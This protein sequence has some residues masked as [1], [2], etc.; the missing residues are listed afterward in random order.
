M[1]ESMDYSTWCHEG[2]RSG[3][4]E[5]TEIHMGSDMVPGG[6]R[7]DGLKGLGA[8]HVLGDAAVLYGPLVALTG[9]RHVD[10][11][12][13]ERARACGVAA[14]RAGVTLVTGGA[15]G[16]ELEAAEACLEEGGSVVVIPGCGPDA[17]YQRP[18]E[19]VL[20]AAASGQGCVC[21]PFPLGTAPRRPQ[22]HQRSALIAS[23]A[24]LIVCP[25]ARPRS[26]TLGTLS[27]AAEL[28]TRIAL[29]E[30]CGVTPR[31]LFPT[32]CDVL[33]IPGTGDALEE[34]L[35]SHM[36]EARA[37]RFC[38]E[39]AQGIELANEAWRVSVIDEGD[40]FA[41]ECETIGDVSGYDY[42]GTLDMRSRDPLDPAAWALE[43]YDLAESF[44]VDHEVE[45]NLGGRGAPG[46]ETMVM[47]FQDIRDRLLPELR[48]IVRSVS[49]E[50]AERLCPTSGNEPLAVQATPAH[51]RALGDDEA[52]ANAQPER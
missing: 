49:S 31:D 27:K 18:T 7:G 12:E 24:D 28:G 13:A 10:G 43:A 30:G 3:S 50:V 48:D 20:R 26:G 52:V 39:L 14:A 2:L 19:G 40:G 41:L 45:I 16:C 11:A 8:L 23:C 5:Y 46:V 36:E 42:I 37:R 17:L 22:F 44:D 29:L 9:S 4:V 38:D 1:S 25:A 34:I 15:I 51:E 47:E 32:L 6:I 35:E 33:V 21:S